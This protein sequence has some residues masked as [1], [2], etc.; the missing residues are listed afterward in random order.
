MIELSVIKRMYLI[1]LPL[2]FTSFG[3]LVIVVYKHSSNHIFAIYFSSLLRRPTQ[4]ESSKP[5]PPPP[6]APALSSSAGSN[7]LASSIAQ[8]RNRLRTGTTIKDRSPK[9]QGELVCIFDSV[10]KSIAQ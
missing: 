1:F 6:P 8:A 9:Q 4:I 5:A 2:I 3:C 10:D 7:D